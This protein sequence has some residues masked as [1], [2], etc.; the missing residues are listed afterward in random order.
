MSPFP[1]K[2]KN[3]SGLPASTP[4]FVTVVGINS[5][6]PENTKQQFYNPLAETWQDNQIS[7]PLANLPKDGDGDPVLNL[8]FIESGIVYVAIEKELKFNGVSPPDFSNPSDPSYHTR[9]DKFEI[10]YL[11]K[12]DHPFI[13][14]TNVDFFCLPL[15][16]QETLSDGT[17]TDAVGFTKTRPAVLA[18]FTKALQGNE[19]SKLIQSDDKGIIRVVAANKALVPPHNFD[20]GFLQA[21]ID[22]VWDFYGWSGNTLTV[23]MSEIEPFNPGY[24][25]LFTGRVVTDQTNPNRGKFVFSGKSSSGNVLPDIVFEKPTAEQIKTSVFGCEDLFNAPNETPRSVPAKNL[26]A[27]FNVGILALQAGD[28]TLTSRDSK[29]IPNG[30]S[31]YTKNFYTQTMMSGQS[32]IVCYNLYA[33]ILHANAEKGL[34]YGFA[35]DDVTQSDSTLAHPDAINAIVTIQKIAGSSNRKVNRPVTAQ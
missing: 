28:L 26:G 18:E 14:T 35:F 12:D 19:W 17:T 25:V 30:W 31:K 20:A 27:A 9:F 21:Y 5:S 1:V 7:N 34:V 33:K 32:E 11:E 3:Q 15:S 13:D 24:D 10:T 2:L 4:I 6:I 22:K 29:L 16:L 23:D 8:P